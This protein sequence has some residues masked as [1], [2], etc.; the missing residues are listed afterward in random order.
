[1]IPVTYRL[2]ER[3]LQEYG[4]FKRVLDV[5]SRWV[6]GGSLEGMFGAAEYVGVDLQKGRN[7]TDVMNAHD[8]TGKFAENSF[9]LAVCFDTL[10]HDDQF[11]LTVAQMKKVLKVGGIMAIG[12]PGVLCPLHE[13]PGDFWRFMDDGVKSMFDGMQLIYFE[14]FEKGGELQAFG[15]KL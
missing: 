11:W 6:E 13:W 10:E 2:V 7:V 8:L 15:K 3:L 9:D 12:V 1:M 5:G 4:P 14:N